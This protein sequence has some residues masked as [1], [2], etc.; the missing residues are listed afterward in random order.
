MLR[1][2]SCIPSTSTTFDRIGFNRLAAAAIGMAFLLVLCQGCGS[3]PAEPP[4]PDG[5]P[6]SAHAPTAVPAPQ[7]DPHEAKMLAEALKKRPDHVP[8]LLRLAVLTLESGKPADAEKY[9]KEVLAQEPANVPARLDLG[10]IQFEAGRIPEAIQ[11]TA[12]I[13]K[14]QPDNADALYNL[15]AI[16]GNLGQRERAIEYWDRLLDS[17]PQSE[18]GKRARQMM[19][20]LRRTEP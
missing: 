12:E 1:P 2:G 4:S 17:S 3:G 13:L 11:T 9:L 8:V 5:H 19:A 20:E 18:S 14:T 16:Y 15:G 7:T 6:V 10:K